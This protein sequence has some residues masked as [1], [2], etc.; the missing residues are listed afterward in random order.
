MPPERVAHVL[1]K[2]EAWAVI[3]R[4]V[5]R[6]G[7]PC[8][9]FPDD[10]TVRLDVQTAFEPDALVYCGS[11][12]PPRTIEVPAPVIVVEA[13][14]EGAAAR[15]HGAKVEGYF[16]LP[17]LAH[18]LIL[19]PERR[20]AIH[21][22]RGRGEVIETRIRVRGS[23]FRSARPRA[24]RGQALSAGFPSPIG[25]ASVMGVKHDVAPGAC[26]RARECW[27][28]RRVFA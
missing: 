3:R 10:P 28:G 1:T 15:D 20:K 6:T 9:V 16:S 5:E 27:R 12:L 22:K 11:P 13:L 26:F 17:G 24:R 23:H 2:G 7:C 21:H 25:R 4:V 18:Y 8:Q 19:D 14:S